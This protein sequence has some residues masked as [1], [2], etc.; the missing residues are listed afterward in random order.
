MGALRRGHEVALP[1]RGLAG[2]PVPQRLPLPLLPHVALERE[3][4]VLDSGRVPR[5]LLVPVQSGQSLRST[6]PL[7]QTPPQTAGLPGVAPLRP[8]SRDNACIPPE[9]R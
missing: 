9:V 2:E 3:A 1:G 8:P 6:S 4:G 7:R 5:L